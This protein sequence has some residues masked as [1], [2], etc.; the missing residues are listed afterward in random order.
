M[1]KALKLD[2]NSV[3]AKSIE[4]KFT[5]REYATRKCLRMIAPLPRIDAFKLILEFTFINIWNS[6]E[7]NIREFRMS[8]TFKRE[9]FAYFVSKY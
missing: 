8:Q 5:S 2:E 6:I 4:V 9:L 1:F 3:A 7:S